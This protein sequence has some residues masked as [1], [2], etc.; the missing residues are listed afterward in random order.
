VR[1]TTAADAGWRCR[2][3]AYAGRRQHRIELYAICNQAK[4]P[5]QISNFLEVHL[6]STDSSNYRD[7]RAGW[8]TFGP[9]AS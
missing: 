9:L 4:M 3:P 1:T 5:L 7:Y 2:M 8:G 6:G